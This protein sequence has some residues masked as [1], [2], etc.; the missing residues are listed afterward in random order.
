L[1]ALRAFCR[2][3]VAII[4][5]AAMKNSVRAM[6]SGRASSA[7]TRYRGAIGIADLDLAAFVITNAVEQLTHLAQSERGG[8]DKA[9]ERQ[10]N[11]LIINYLIKR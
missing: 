11:R 7:G 10:L 2:N 1:T 4:R 9:L 5:K 6:I 3:S 8:V